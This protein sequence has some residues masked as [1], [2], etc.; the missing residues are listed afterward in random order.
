MATIAPITR[1]A[2]RI[3]AKRQLLARLTNQP[4]AGDRSWTRAELYED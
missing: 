3:V 4:S 2:G 1:Q